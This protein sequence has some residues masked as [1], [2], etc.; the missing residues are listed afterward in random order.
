MFVDEGVL[1]GK[2]G[3]SEGYVE[4]PKKVFI[5]YTYIYNYIYLYCV[6]TGL[7]LLEDSVMRWAEG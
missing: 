3:W 4:N 5:H 6:Y 2:K 1:W 7:K